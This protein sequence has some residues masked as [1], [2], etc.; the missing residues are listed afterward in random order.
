MIK[1]Y[2]LLSVLFLSFLFSA[3]A[4]VKELGNINLGKNYTIASK[5]L[6]ETRNIQIYTPKSY[7]DSIT[8]PYPVLYVLDGQ[9]FFNSVVSFQKM[10]VKRE[11]FPEFI[12]VGIKTDLRKRRTLLGKDSSKFI[13]FLETELINYVDATYRTSKQKERIFFGWEI[14]G[15]IGVDVLA[16]NPSL[17]SGYILPSPSNLWDFRLNALEKR[18][19]TLDSSNAPFLLVTAAPDENWLNDN[20]QLRSFFTTKKDNK[21]NWR[22][23]ILEREQHHST[24]FKT[25]NEGIIDYFYNYNPIT[26]R[27][28]KQYEE[29]GGLA[30]LKAFYKKR[31]ERF[32]MSTEISETTKMFILYNAVIENNYEQFLYYEKAFDGHIETSNGA[33][34]FH[35]YAGFYLKHN[36]TKEALYFYN[37]AIKK[38]GDSKLLYRGLGDVYSK[39]NKKSKAKKAYKKALK[40]DPKY[41]QALDGLNK[42]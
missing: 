14:A 28:L 24:P 32:N 2:T 13:Q 25:I 40:I 33:N 1:K 26:F 16:N 34:W 41:K 4:Q 7:K 11:Y 38:L 35:R 8:K 3:N 27:T 29:F 36:N 42:L 6:K 37:Y 15:G 9:E 5:V 18:M 22:Y 12:V 19:K 10:L 23:S 30:G 21:L 20:K 39:M 17:F 31:G